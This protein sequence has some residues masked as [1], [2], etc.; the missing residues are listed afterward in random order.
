MAAAQPQTL[1]R[2]G[3]GLRRVRG[4]LSAPPEAS[5]IVPVNARADL[6]NVLALLGE[7]ASYHGTHFFE[8]LIVINNYPEDDPPAEL[9]TY[10]RAGLRVVGVPN[11]WKT[12]QVVSF[13]ARIPG[14]RAA[15]SER[16]IHLDADCRIPNPSLL[17]DWY[18]EQ[19]D[20]GAQAAYTHVDYY[21]LRT[22]WSVRARIL[23]H[24]AARWI[25]RVVLRVPTL[26]GSNYAVERTVLL[27][28]YDQGLLTDDLNVGPSVKAAGGR[29]AY[30][31]A[32]ELRVL[33]SGRRFRGGWRKLA[34]YLRYRLLYNLR[35][36][37]VRRARAAGGRNPY[38]QKPLR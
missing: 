12:G 10:A 2:I 6:E 29:I 22:L 36:L 25:K 3:D 8:V 28:L 24:H 7:V 11:V 21:D 37:P 32:S 19:F 35:V 9:E 26:R 13:T 23:A 1:E 4:D 5:I 14:A 18:V 30:S 38:H 34:R 31:G 33:T 16:T 17:F 20:R 15:A 27:R